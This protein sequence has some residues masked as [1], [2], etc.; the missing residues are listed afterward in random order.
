M[1]MAQFL[2]KKIAY[3]VAFLI[4]PLNYMG[5]LVD[6]IPFLHNR[7]RFFTDHS[8]GEAVLTK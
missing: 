3:V 8:W 2:V 6:M 5:Y 7:S 1:R 4:N